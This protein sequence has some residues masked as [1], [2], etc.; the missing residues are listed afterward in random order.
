MIRA[1]GWA[2]YDADTPLRRLNFD[3]REPGPDDVL[4][5]IQYC[6]VCHSDLHFAKNDLGG[7]NY[8]LVPG[9]EIVGLV[10]RVG[11]A[12]TRFKQGDRVGVGCL[13]GADLDCPECQAG[14]EQF[15]PKA[16]G[17][18]GALDAD[19][20]RTQGGYS[21]CVTVH[22]HFVLSIPDALPMDAAAP[23]LCAGITTWSPLRTWRAGPGMKV[24]VVGLGGLGHMAVKLAAALGCEVTVISTSP[25][26]R[27]D[28][29][30]LGAHDFL[31]STDKAA[32]KAAESR[33]DLIIDSVAVFHEPNP[34]LRSLA[35]DGTLVL[36]GLIPEALP[37][38]AFSMLGKR[39]RLAAS[40]IGGIR[41]TQEMLDF[42][43]EHGITADIEII[44]IDQINE[45]YERMVR[46][47]VRYRFVIDMS[48]LD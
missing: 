31:V 2:A 41:E 29:L 16:I 47:D 7:T 27:A 48:T 30:A 19:G 32:M 38:K 45:A 10:S 44:R 35:R 39:R 1:S 12:V 26:K 4:I 17:T 33:F 42:C 14:E 9:H 46:S 6:G 13:V 15:C 18:Y 25:G 36:L 43:G 24:G 28:A 34:L 8:P 23:L 5:E 22:E 21:N 37:V 40:P 11:E 20:T 3:R